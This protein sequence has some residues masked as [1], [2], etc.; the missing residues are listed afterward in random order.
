MKILTHKFV[1]FIPEVL[2]QDVIY[3]SMS[4]STAIHLCMCGCGNEVV[5]P[6][7][8]RDWSIIYN[9]SVSLRPSIGNWDFIC[10]SHYFITRSEYVKAYN[11]CD[12]ERILK[13]AGDIT[14]KLV[15]IKTMGVYRNFLKFLFSWRI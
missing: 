2:E 7:T 1:E 15:M 4:Y 11:N 13:A 10:Q 8:K 3:I 5:T 9:G 12:D 14:E 6:L